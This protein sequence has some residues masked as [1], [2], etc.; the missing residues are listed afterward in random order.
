M[1]FSRIVNYE[2][3]SY[4]CNIEEFKMFILKMIKKIISCDQLNQQYESF[5]IVLVFDNA[6][7]HRNKESVDFFK[8]TNFNVLTLPTYNP[9]FN[10]VELVFSFLKSKFYKCSTKSM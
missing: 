2:V 1:T 9:M 10:S 6:S 3:S 5:K 7:F 8:S 4:S